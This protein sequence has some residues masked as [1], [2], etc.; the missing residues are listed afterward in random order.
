M[1]IDTIESI[2]EKLQRDTFQDGNTGKDGTTDPE[3]EILERLVNESVKARDERGA[4]SRGLSFS[5]MAA[6]NAARFLGDHSSTFTGANIQSR[7]MEEGYKLPSDSTSSDTGVIK[8]VLNRTQ[9]STIATHAAMTERP[10]QIGFTPVE[11]DDDWL[12]VLKKRAS[13]R[14]LMYLEN[15]VFVDQVNPRTPLGEPQLKGFTSEQLAGEEFIEDAK[16]AWL[17]EN[18]VNPSTGMPLLSDD[19]FTIVNDVNTARAGKRLFDNRW[20][21]SDADSAISEHALNCRVFGWQP[22]FFQWDDANQRFWFE[23]PH[24]LSVHPD[25]AHTR[26]SQFDYI[27]WDYFVSL[28]KAKMLFPDHESE[29]IAAADEGKLSGDNDKL[30]GIYGEDDY[31]RAMVQIRT[32]WIKNTKVPVTPEEASREGVVSSSDEQGQEDMLISTKTGEEVEE[33]TKEKPEG[34]NWPMTHGILQVRCLPQI[35]KTLD[36]RRCPYITEPMGWTVNLPTFHRPWGIGDPYRLEHIQQAINRELTVLTNHSR[37]YAYPAEFW[38]SDLWEDLRARGFKTHIRPGRVVPIPKQIYERMIQRTGKLSVT[39][40]PPAL[41]GDRVG[42]LQT[43]L[44]EHDR[45]SGH[46]EALQGRTPGAQT[47]GRTMQQIRQEA[48]GPLGMQAKFLEATVTR[49]AHLAMDSMLKWMEK[50]VAYN[51]LNAYPKFVVDEF[52]RRLEISRYNVDVKATMGRGILQQIAR[53]EAQQLFQLGLLDQ[54]TALEDHDRDPGPIMRRKK[55]DMEREVQ[56]Q[57]IMEKQAMNRQ[58]MSAMQ[59]A[60]PPGGTPTGTAPPTGPAQTAGPAG[61]ENRNE[62]L[63]FNQSPT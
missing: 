5:D 29:L 46:V 43:M 12:F 25:P 61:G 59:A 18:L 60:S 32:G 15:P 36:K 13:Q 54:T 42:L 31:E 3:V 57:G 26:I 28:D 63:Q 62:T 37:F 11:S 41:P 44:A 2:G 19:D 51:I 39:Q 55:Q 21:E 7:L 22:I 53:D 38:P 27:V 16:A 4:D 50:D 47:S 9:T 10:V 1:A 24:A 20:E 33:P 34:K 8:A 30:P 14:L 48:R 6:R 17:M 52:I 40:D 23:N 58:Q 45:I 49:L 35:G 56:I